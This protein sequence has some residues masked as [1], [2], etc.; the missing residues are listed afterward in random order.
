M[1]THHF[2]ST[3]I[4]KNSLPESFEI[5]SGV[6]NENESL[7]VNKNEEKITSSKF[8]EITSSEKK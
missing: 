5:P 6:K 3:K 4:G 8:F 7:L 1:K 2:W